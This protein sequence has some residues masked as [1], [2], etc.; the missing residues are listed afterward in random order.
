M[1]LQQLEKQETSEVLLVGTHTQMNGNISS[2]YYIVWKGLR[3]IAVGG[4]I[5]TPAKP[6]MFYYLT[7]V[8]HAR[9]Y[10]H[11]ERDARLLCADCHWLLGAAGVCT[12][13]G[14][15]ARCTL[16]GRGLVK[17]S[18]SRSLPDRQRIWKCCWWIWS[19]SQWYLLSMLLVRLALTVL[20]AMPTAHRLSQSRIVAG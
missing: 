16:T 3:Y 13:S 15:S 7:I 19:R 4:T 17:K 1:S 10:W 14:M 6:I 18:A 2:G 9:R 5:N 11:R 8:G 12:S 20:V